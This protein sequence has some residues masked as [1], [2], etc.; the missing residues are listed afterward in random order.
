MSDTTTVTSTSELMTLLS[1]RAT[2]AKESSNLFNQNI[3][4]F[5]GKGLSE[6]VNGWDVLNV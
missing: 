6:P 4:E 5:T 2:K 1:E 3:M